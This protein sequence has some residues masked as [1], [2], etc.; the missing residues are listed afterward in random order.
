MSNKRILEYSETA[1]SASDDYLYMDGQ[2]NG[3]RKIKPNAVVQSATV[4]QNLSSYVNND[5][6]NYIDDAQNDI[7]DIRADLGELSNLETEDKSNVVAAI[8]EAASSG[9]NGSYIDT[10][11]EELVIGSS[12]LS[13]IE[14]QLA[15]I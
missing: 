6:A 11:N 2:T 8:N 14:S 7:T 12:A 5:L 3:S 15:S 1:A 9:G 10:T 13:T 4:F